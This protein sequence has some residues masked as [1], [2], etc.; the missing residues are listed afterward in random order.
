MQPPS[1]DDLRYVLAVKRGQTLAA[2][3]RQLRVD[4]TTVS[5][6]LSSLQAALNMRLVR[7]TPDHRLLL[8]RAGETVARR[9]EV[10]ERQ[11]QSIGH[12][13]HAGQERCTGTVR[14]T[15]VPILINRLLAGA[16]KELLESHPGLTLE[17]LP[18]G[19]DY[20]LTR[21]EADI[22]VRL[23]RPRN[24][25]RNV[26]MRRIGVLGY[27][28]FAPAAVAPRQLRRLS[29]ITFDDEMSHLPQAR[30]IASA[31]QGAESCLAGVR[32]RDAETALEATA[33]GLG[34]TLLPTI[35]AARDPRLRRL[36]V[37]ACQ[38]ARSREI[39]LLVRADQ[40]ER[41]PVAATI[42]WLEKLVGRSG[43]S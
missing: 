37:D 31:T 40:A 8:T 9:A 28:I 2:A 7:R 38:P 30:W 34:K 16:A 20:S 42:R 12:A 5:R 33:A 41:P 29:W 10:M 4:D 11:V 25:G 22:A 21:R 17:L 3:A 23:A 13:A 36:D 18:D 24:G 32:V 6:R 35:V 43:G 14:L 39:W 27:A 19:R 15:S 1:W 26:R